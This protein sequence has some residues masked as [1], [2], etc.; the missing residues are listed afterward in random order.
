MPRTVWRDRGILACLRAGSSIAAVCMLICLHLQK[1]IAEI[2]KKIAFRQRL[3]V[4]SDRKVPREE[5]KP[6]EGCG[7]ARLQGKLRSEALGPAHLPSA[8]RG[9]RPVIS[10]L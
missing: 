2:P 10:V 9:P 5:R 4:N 8:S 7:G 1:E 3:I 6:G